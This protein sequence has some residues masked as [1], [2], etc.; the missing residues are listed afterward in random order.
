[1]IEALALAAWDRCDALA[2]CSDE[3]G[4]ITRLFLGEGMRQ[5]HKR[6]ARWMAEAGLHCRVDAA[7]NLIGRRTAA[8]PNAPI[9]LFGSHLDSVPNAGRYDGSLGVLLALA[10][11]ESLRGQ[12]LPFHIDVVGFSEEEGVRYRT[13]YLGSSAVA[14]RFDPRW[15]DR[16]DDRGITLRRA[17]TSFGLHPGEVPLAAYDPAH[18]LGYLEAHIEQGIVLERESRGLGVVGTIAGQ[19]RLRLIFTGEARHAGTTPMELRRDSLV[20]AAMVIVAANEYATKVEG[21]RATVGQ[22][23]NA[24]NASNV[25]PGRTEVSLDV[26]H[27]DDEVRQRA[28]QD[29]LAAARRISE[30]QGTELE[31]VNDMAQ[32]AVPMDASLTAMLCDAVRRCDPDGRP[33]RTLLSGAGHDAVA[34]AGFCPVALLFLRSPGGISHHPDEAVR[35]ED[36]AA[37]IKALG[38]F[39][40]RLAE[41]RR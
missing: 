18:L 28:L 1:M 6:V 41:T 13:A 35:Q 11:V 39:I 15:L 4:A 5:A 2:A 38:L 17:I 26:R 40:G 21:L 30:A 22:V 7:G 36:I 9:L 32:P 29:L 20:A 16:T 24:P 14:G 3:S 25:V 33:A 10:T 12:A 37:A 23:A 27:A 34:L 19:N 8:R 31:V